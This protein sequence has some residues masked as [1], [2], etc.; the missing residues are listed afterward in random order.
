MKG[1]ICIDDIFEFVS[2]MNDFA[3]KTLF[4]RGSY[5]TKRY[6]VR[7]IQYFTKFDDT[8]CDLF[9]NE[10]GGI[11]YKSIANRVDILFV[12]KNKTRK[13]NIELNRHYYK[14][15]FNKNYSY[16]FKI[17]GDFYAD[18]LDYEMNIAVEQINFN[19]F[20][21]LEDRN[22]LQEKYLLQN[23]KQLRFIGDVQIHHVYLPNASAFDEMGKDLLLFTSTSFK[24]M[25]ALAVDNEERMSVVED[26]KRFGS[27]PE[28]VD[29]YDHDKFEKALREEIKNV[30]WDE[31][32]AEG[33]KVGMEE[34]ITTGIQQNKK[35]I[36]KTMLEFGEDLEK[37][38]KYCNISHE[39]I[40]KIK[41][42]SIEYKTNSLK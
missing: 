21:S 24:E 14:T 9:M 6:L 7:L 8:A 27:D 4:L 32:L 33:K 39:Q 11:S 30:A 18:K 34:G 41:E 31:G 15:I 23:E 22:M 29:Y 13:I 12:A 28:F 20:C 38:S 17:A 19:G 26:L 42:E 2:L 40:L 1:G 16:L 10:L 3:F 37:I 36:V 5:K 25:E 35:D